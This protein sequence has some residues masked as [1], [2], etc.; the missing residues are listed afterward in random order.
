M[1]HNSTNSVPLHLQVNH[2]LPPEKQ[3][4]NG[5]LQCAICQKSFNSESQAT[6]HFQSPKHRQKL[7]SVEDSREEIS[8]APGANGLLTQ[9]ELNTD[10][11]TSHT[12]DVPG[13]VDRTF[14]LSPAKTKA[15]ELYCEIC[16]LMM[17]SIMQMKTHLQGSKHKNNVASMYQN[18]FLFSLLIL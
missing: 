12:Y 6:Q 1:E 9:Q 13:N 17:N 7:N 5:N 2:N 3:A 15:M 11:G 16:G 10:D 14:P 4:G 18:F 8:S